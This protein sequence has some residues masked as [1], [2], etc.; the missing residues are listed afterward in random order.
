MKKATD[1]QKKRATA[2]GQVPGRRCNNS[3]FQLS[4]ISFD[5]NLGYAERPTCSAQPMKTQS[6]SKQAV[7]RNEGAAGFRHRMN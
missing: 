4:G 3:L 5:P 7:Q 6:N 2:N 1:F